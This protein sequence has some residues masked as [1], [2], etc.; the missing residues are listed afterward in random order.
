MWLKSDAKPVVVPQF[1]LSGEIREAHTRPVDDVLKS[2]TV[3]PD[4]G[5]WN[6]PSFP[7]PKK[8]PGEYRMVQTL[9]PQNA[10]TIKDGHPDAHEG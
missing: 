10:A 2:G 3:E 5:P 9:R 1:R 4:V 6:T 8:R 7:V